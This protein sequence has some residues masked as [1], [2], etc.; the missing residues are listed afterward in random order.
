MEDGF[1]VVSVRIE[2]ERG[3]VAAAVLGP[4][5][6]R[7]VV[8]TAVFQGGGMP[9]IASYIRRLDCRLLTRIPTWSMTSLTARAYANAVTWDLGLAAPPTRTCVLVVEGPDF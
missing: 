7:P 5:A 3:V 8:A 9:T 2:D 4:Q 6:G 1:D